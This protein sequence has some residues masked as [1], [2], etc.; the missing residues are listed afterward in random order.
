M[1]PEQLISCAL[2]IGE[3][4][5]ISGA[6]ISRVETTIELI[7][8]AYGCRRTDV[9]TITSSIVVSI[10]SREGT[11]I[12][13]SRRITGSRTDLTR[14]DKL[15]SLSRYICKHTPEYSYVEE[16]LQAICSAKPYP[17]WLA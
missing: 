16:Q 5:L 7:C 9:F 4:M 17:L 10:V 13:Q 11:H 2:D 3:Q 12:S 15:N 6:E 1:N 14:L 8:S